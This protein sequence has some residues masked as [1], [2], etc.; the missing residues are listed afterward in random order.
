MDTKAVA[1]F[2]ERTSTQSLPRGVAS[3]AKLKIL[4][5]LGVMFAGLDTRAARIARRLEETKAGTG[6]ATLFGSDRKVPASEAAFANTI[7]AT[8]LD[9]DDG[10]WWGVHP[11][12]A[13]IPALL[14][15]AEMENS[16]GRELLEAVVAAYE[17]H[18]RSGD[19]FSPPPKLFLQH[20][21]GTCGA[22]GVAA[23]AAKL[24][25]LSEEQTINAI[26]IAGAHAPIAPLWG[27]AEKG[28]MTKEC[29]GWGAKTGVEAALMARLGFTGPPII[30]DDENN[31]R[32]ALD[33]LGTTYEIMNSYFKPY[34]A[35]R[36]AH[37]P[38]DIVLDIVKEH[39]LVPDDILKVTV[40]TRKWASSLINNRPASVEQAVYSIP[41]TVGAAIAEGEVG[42]KQMREE[43]LNDPHIL[44]Q[45]DKVELVY[46]PELDEGYQERWKAAVHIDAGSES[47][48]VQRPFAKGDFQNPFTEEELK[49]K[50]KGAVSGVFGNKGSEEIINAILQIEALPQIRQLTTLIKSSI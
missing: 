37:V 16:S 50:F 39:D 47:Y 9:F 45:V 41:F 38:I 46:N 36:M 17:V 11:A 42:P 25:H 43:R 32:S 48:R 4:D 49:A 18:L 2:I 6:D 3:T 19:I 31:D 10:H 7:A 12:G 24:L 34:S 15:V 13:V 30:F 26:G 29:M 27:L 20:C 1:K 35:C 23:G 44:K 33:T 21:S 22:Y 14:A 40:E 8:D 5:T 28:P